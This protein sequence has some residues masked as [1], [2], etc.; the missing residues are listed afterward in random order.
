ME[1]ISQSNLSKY[2]NG[3]EGLISDEAII[4]IMALL[5]FPL[6]FLSVR[7]RIQESSINM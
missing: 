5:D 1:G 2:E 6:A 3:F 4:N 7:L